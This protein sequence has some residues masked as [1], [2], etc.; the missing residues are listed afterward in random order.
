MVQTDNVNWTLFKDGDQEALGKIF[1]F[2]FQELYFYG[3]K[4]I[5]IPDM[6]KDVIQEMFVHLWDR[7]ENIGDVKNVKPYLLVT[8]RNELI[9]ASKR[10]RVTE[11]ELGSKSEPFTL[12]AEDFIIDQENSKELNQ[13]LVSSLNTLSERQ[14]EIIMLRFYHN[15]G[16]TELAEVLEMNVQS[17]RNLLFRALAK[18]RKDLKD[19]GFHSSDNIEIILF[20]FF[21]KKNRIS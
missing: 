12:A 16:F 6:V 1:E 19:T 18:I 15:L 5:P 2:Y 7:R 17:V 14:R 3:L 11:I 8:L 10:N 20:T 9:H 4:I 21:Q 13:G